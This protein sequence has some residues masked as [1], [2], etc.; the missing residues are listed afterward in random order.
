MAQTYVTKNLDPDD[1]G[2]LA[3]QA[4]IAGILA[5]RIAAEALSEPAL[6]QT[7]ALQNVNVIYGA[8]TVIACQANAA[9]I[10]SSR[11]DVSVQQF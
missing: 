5:Q 4:T 1:V 11:A 2:Q 10:P 6:Y 9:F 3:R 7:G 8:T